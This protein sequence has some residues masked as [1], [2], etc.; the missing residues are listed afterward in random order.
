MSLINVIKGF[1]IG[2]AAVVPGLSASIFAIVVGLYEALLFAVSDLR[3][4]FVKHLLFLLPI[5]VGGLLGVLLSVDLVLAVTERFPAY[6][7]LFFA[8]LV[9]GS[10]PLTLLKIR[11]ASDRELPLKPRGGQIGQ[12]VICAAAFGVVLV[13]ANMAGDGEHIAM[14]QMD[15]VWDFVHLMAVGA[16]AISLMILPGVSGSLILIILGQFGTIY[17]A[18]SSMGDFLISLVSQ[19][20]DRVFTSFYTLFLLVPF[21]LGAVLGLFSIA[22]LMSWL[23]KQYERLVYYGVLGTLFATIVVLFHMGVIHNIHGGD[24]SEA[25]SLVGIGGLCVVG[26]YLCTRLLDR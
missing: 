19:D 13:M 23:L 16:V 5:G 24:W 22:K 11:E 12:W 3:H 14:Y 26:G 18:A 9:M 4:N 8:G 17:N 15:S 2:V 10:V 6:A 7:Y 1:L 25:A 21:G 20:Y